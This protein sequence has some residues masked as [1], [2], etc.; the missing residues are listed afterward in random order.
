MLIACILLV[1]IHP[2][3]LATNVEMSNAKIAAF[4]FAINLY[5]LGGSDKLTKK[6]YSVENLM[7]FPGH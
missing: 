3:Q 6:G 1:K 5:D 7:N 4:I 2:A